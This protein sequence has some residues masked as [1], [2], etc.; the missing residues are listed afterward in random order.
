MFLLRRFLFDLEVHHA[1]GYE[2]VLSQVQMEQ[3][4]GV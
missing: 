4:V 3:F 2:K 1:R